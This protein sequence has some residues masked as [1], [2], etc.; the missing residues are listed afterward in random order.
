M[1]ID[2]V[3]LFTKVCAEYAG[4]SILKRAGE[5]GLVE[6]RVINLRDYTP[7]RHRTADDRPYGGGA[8]MVLKAE[9]LFEAV[10]DL[11][12][13]ASRVVLLS[14][15]GRLFDQE[16]ALRLSREPHLILIAGRYEGV[17][18]RVSEFL[19]DE[20]ISIGDYILTGGELPALAVADSVVRLLPGVLGDPESA[21]D[22]S[23][24]RGR[25]EYP[26]YTRPEDYRGM[27]V[28]PVLLSGDHE[29]VARWRAREAL[30]L[31]RERRPDLL[32]KH[33]PDEEEEKWL[34]EKDKKEGK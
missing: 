17:D 13:P 3:T 14:P 27:K 21:V 11:K 23:F 29:A 15:R 22:E 8:G 20:E 25:L 7:D 24:S 34:E 28:P 26:Q 19:V 33:P 6:I 12:T 18:E 9:P 32:E 10:G 30:M 4:E 5:Q 16:Q 31:T 1:R 2:I